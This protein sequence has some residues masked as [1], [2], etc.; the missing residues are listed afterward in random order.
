M[1]GEQKSGNNNFQWKK[2]KVET[3][4]SSLQ[5]TLNTKSGVRVCDAALFAYSFIYGR[6]FYGDMIS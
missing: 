5:M 1:N 3:I 4:V 2:Y 6:H